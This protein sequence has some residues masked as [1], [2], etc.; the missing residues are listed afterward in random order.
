MGQLLGQKFVGKENKIERPTIIT[1]A[2]RFRSRI[3]PAGAKLSR[4][5]PRET[6]GAEYDVDIEEIL[7]F[8]KDTEIHRKRASLKWTMGD[9]EKPAKLADPTRMPKLSMLIFAIFFVLSQ[10]QARI[11]GAS[12]ILEEVAHSGRSDRTQKE[13]IRITATDLKTD[14][15][16]GANKKNTEEENESPGNNSTGSSDLHIK[17]DL[18]KDFSFVLPKI[19]KLPD[20]LNHYARVTE[21]LQEGDIPVLFH[22]PRSGGSTLKEITSDCFSLV[23]ASEIGLGVDPSAAVLDEVKVLTDATNGGQY[24]NVDTTWLGG[25]ERAKSLNIAQSG[26][27]DIL[28]TPYYFQAG[29]LFDPQHRGRAFTIMRHPVDRAVS[30]YYYM[31]DLALNGDENMKSALNGMDL[32]QYAKSNLVENNWVT[33]FLTN[34]LGGALT[35]EHEALAREILAQKFLIGLL[36]DR[37]QSLERFVQYFKWPIKGEKAEDCIDRRMGWNWS[38]K[39]HLYPKVKEGSDVWD[40]LEEANT[41][42]IRL[43]HY[44]EE[45]FHMQAVLFTH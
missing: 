35:P 18:R 10:L 12:S 1:M 25:L 28:V 29:A 3:E 39:G 27:V 6:F 33:R 2:E 17:T 30:M 41:F 37:Q 5:S 19:E 23:Q 45:L 7:P 34:T 26:L 36:S 22:I 43:F 21:P 40:L 44:A 8:L 42:D 31:N 16:G 15:N 20:E 24:L 13:W 14:D 38:N 9:L 11:F 4:S 32:E